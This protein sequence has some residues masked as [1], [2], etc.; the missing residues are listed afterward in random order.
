VS[1]TWAGGG[2]GRGCVP[3]R[4]A[5]PPRLGCSLRGPPRCRAS[6][7][8][9]NVE[10]RRDA[11]RAPRAPLTPTRHHQSC[12]GA[13]CASN[14]FADQTTGACITCPDGGTQREWWDC[15]EFSRLG[16]AR[17]VRRAGAAGAPPPALPRWGRRRTGTRRSASGSHLRRSQLAAGAW[18]RGRRA[19]FYCVK[20]HLAHLLTRTHT[21]PPTPPRQQR[22]PN[23]NGSRGIPTQA[24]PHVC[25][26]M[27]AADAEKLRSPGNPALMIIQN[28]TT[29]TCALRQT[30][31]PTRRLTPRLR[32]PAGPPAP[33][34]SPRARLA[35][36][37]CMRIRSAAAAAAG[38]LVRSSFLSHVRLSSAPARLAQ[39]SLPVC[40]SSSM[41]CR[42]HCASS[43][44]QLGP[45]P[46]PHPSAPP[47]IARLPLGRQA[48]P[49]PHSVFQHPSLG[50]AL[51]RPQRGGG[52]PT[53]PPGGAST[54]RRARR[55]AL[56]PF[57]PLSLPCFTL[58][59]PLALPF[60]LISL[61]RLRS[62]ALG[63][64]LRAGPR[65]EP[66]RTGP[67]PLAPRARPSP[68][69]PTTGRSLA[70]HRRPCCPQ[71]SAHWRRWAPPASLPIRSPRPPPQQL[72]PRVTWVNA[73]QIADLRRARL[74]RACLCTLRA[75]ST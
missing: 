43:G 33:A 74:V 16:G 60:G 22:A 24:L 70:H 66:F 35:A 13:M 64:D 14:Q 36:T 23:R 37:P 21:R 32:P 58:H 19:T 68:G 55:R 75:N 18:A 31:A 71:A 27:R 15:S 65:P 8:P 72:W 3:R 46:H 30:G 48:P 63:R 41:R 50:R 49:A 54:N 28:L 9:P 59:C 26:D 17:P 40:D 62:R 47:L 44:P 53:H 69:A 73:P 67:P 61:A 56:A 38:G 4:A 45:S 29:K 52:A 6:C 57:T 5:P 42:T 2:R 39:S 12:A 25:H 7:G 20:L 34:S 10:G 51:A 11:L 1:G